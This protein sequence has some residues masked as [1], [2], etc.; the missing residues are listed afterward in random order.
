MPQLSGFSMAAIQQMM[1][2]V[3]PWLQKVLLT[4]DFHFLF[5]ALIFIVANPALFPLLI[6]ARRSFWA[7]CTYCSKTPDAQ[8][9]VWKIC[10]P[11]WEK[12]KPKEAEV[13]QQSA[14]AEILV[15]FWLTVSL[16]LPSRQILTCIL[17]WNYLRMRFMPLS[18]SS[19]HH[20][21]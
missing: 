7:V 20:V 21:K 12:V 11:A 6:L 16:F 19:A 2:T 8:G 5:F 9:L 13:L 15:A 3:Q 10:K 1:P 18:R 17:Y 14:L 4:P